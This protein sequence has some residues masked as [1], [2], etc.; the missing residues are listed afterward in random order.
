MPSDRLR[1]RGLISRW[2]VGNVYGQ[3]G[4][5][6]P[7]RVH[8]V[9][10]D[11]RVEPG[12]PEAARPLA[13]ELR[14][15]SAWLGR[16]GPR[17]GVRLSGRLEVIEVDALEIHTTRG[18]GDHPRTLG[19]LE[20]WQEPQ[21]ERERPATSVAGVLPRSR[22]AR[23]SI[24][25]KSARVVHQ[26]V[27]PRLRSRG[28]VLRRRR[29]TQ[30]SPCRPRRSRSGPRRGRPRGHRGRPPVDSSFRPT[31]MTRAPSAA[32]ASD[33]ARPRPS[34]VTRTVRPS[35]APSGRAAPVEQA[36]PHR[37]AGPAEAPDDRQLQ[38]SIDQ[39]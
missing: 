7:A 11:T 24:R 37:D 12:Q 20:Q 31:R 14:L 4:R 32:R 25:I 6:G 1:R 19:T 13:D 29:R 16:V 36:T 34:P 33:A 27:E 30:A 18:H 35:S 2:N 3:P 38:A 8:R 23:G 5:V 9:D 21:H 39:R 10:R 15:A 28:H 22:P 26:D 17:A